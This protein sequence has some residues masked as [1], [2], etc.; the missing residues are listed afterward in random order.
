[1]THTGAFKRDITRILVPIVLILLILTYASLPFIS[2][3]HPCVGEDCALCAMIESR[4]ELAL[5]L[6]TVSTLTVCRDYL[7]SVV[8]RQSRIAAIKAPTPI[9]LR[10]KLS[11]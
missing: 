2:H 6:L 4:R 8:C 10:V 9:D 3:S 5:C 7:L 1:M 11:D